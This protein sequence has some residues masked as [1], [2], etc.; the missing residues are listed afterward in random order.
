MAKKLRDW[1]SNWDLNQ[2]LADIN[3]NHLT[4][5]SRQVAAG[6]CFIA[7]QGNANNGEDYIAQAIAQGAV[8]I[9]VDAESKVTTSEVAVIKVAELSNQLPA[10]AKAFYQQEKLATVIGVTGTNGK[11]TIA[12]GLC[13]ALNLL[14]NQ[15][16]LSGTLGCGPLDELATTANTTP[17][18]LSNWRLLAEASQAGADYL[19][20]EV[21]SHGIAQNRVAS[22]PITTAIFT[23]LSHEHLDYHATLEEYGACKRRLFLMDSVKQVVLNSLDDFG[24]Q[25][26]FDD[27]IKASKWILAAADTQGAQVCRLLD[28]K[29][30][31]DGVQIDCDLGGAELSI[32]SQL[33]G[34][35]NAENILQIT[36]TL[37]SLGYP[38]AKIVDVI[39]Q[40]LPVKGRMQGIQKPNQPLVIVDYAHTPDALQNAL[41]AAR[42]HTQSK[43]WCVFGCGGDRDASKRPMMGQVAAELADCVVVT[44]DNPRSEHPQAIIEQIETGIGDNNNMTRIVDRKQAIE[45]AIANANQ[46]DVVLIA[47]KGHEDYQEINGVRQAFSDSEVATK[48]M[49]ARA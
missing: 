36:L 21:S 20:M 40:L 5:D 3:I 11:T 35:F 28:L 44:S 12:T 26:S 37:S 39:A 49:E 22:L 1:L 10:L 9:M 45:F 13:Q 6:D 32:R 17:D 4:L 47:G 8:A 7:I 33:L 14:G 19:V 42:A 48:C 30:N 2:P 41:E 25:L 43:L 38:I 16:W 46:A 24:R 34:A 18:I 15:A 29:L 31:A 23:N 27:Q